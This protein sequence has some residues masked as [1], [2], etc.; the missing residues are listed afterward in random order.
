[1][2]QKL[3]VYFKVLRATLNPHLDVNALAANGVDISF[4][5]LLNE[6]RGDYFLPMSTSRLQSLDQRPHFKPSFSPE[7]P[8]WC[9]RYSLILLEALGDQLLERHEET[10]FRGIDGT[11]WHHRGSVALS[12]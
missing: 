8:R 10:L 11:N 5:D 2:Y 6:T 7:D 3:K 9:Y 4:I 12:T 1:M